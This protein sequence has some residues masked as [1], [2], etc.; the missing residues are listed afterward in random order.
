[1][2]MMLLSVWCGVVSPA[3]ESETD[4]RIRKLEEHIERQNREIRRLK[5]SANNV[6]CSYQQGDNC[7][8]M[9][10]GGSNSIPPGE[11]LGGLGEYRHGSLYQVPPDVSEKPGTQGMSVQGS[12]Q[13]TAAATLGVSQ[14]YSS[15][16]R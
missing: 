8:T 3:H 7:G 13:P 4:K 12:W 5:T 16:R 9:E 1:M 15:G 10:Y 2:L 14:Q 11:R 6:S